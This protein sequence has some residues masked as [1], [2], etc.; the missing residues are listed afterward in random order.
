M[1]FTLIAYDV[2]KLSIKQSI[3]KEVESKELDPLK[4]EESI[5]QLPTDRRIQATFLLKTIKSLDSLSSSSVEK[6]RILNAAAYFT[7]QKIAKTYNWVSPERSTFYNSLTTSLDLRKGNQPERDDLVDMY[8]PLEKFLRS[9]VYVSSDP[10]KGYLKKQ[11]FD[12]TGYSVE[13]DII[14]LSTQVQ[15][16]RVEL[17]QSAK[18][19][20]LKVL[21]AKNPVSKGFLG[22]GGLF[23]GSTPTVAEKKGEGVSPTLV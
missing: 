3:I 16:W 10:R 9:N 8:G 13:T 19:L 7:H 22:L 14:T 1:S 17:I 12:I 2:L 11:P 20:H 23:G 18:E 6:A 15:A 4:L 5:E 21:E